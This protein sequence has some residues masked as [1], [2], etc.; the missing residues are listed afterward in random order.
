MSSDARRD[1]RGRVVK[2][3]DHVMDATR[4]MARSGIVRMKRKPPKGGEG[5][6]KVILFDRNAANLGWMGG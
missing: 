4:Y 5:E 1:S 6:N 3:N 2:S